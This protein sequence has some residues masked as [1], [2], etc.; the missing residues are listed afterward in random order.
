MTTQFVRSNNDKI[1][2]GVCG[3][4]G[5]YLGIDPVFVR[6]A[7]VLGVLVGGVSPLVYVLLWIVM[8]RE[9]TVPPTTV[10]Y[11]ADHPRPVEQWKYDPYT[12]Q[13]VRR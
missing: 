12:G 1:I 8:P 11:V 9:Y 7:F 10:H 13:P 5:H 3:G 2:A 6:L 4:L